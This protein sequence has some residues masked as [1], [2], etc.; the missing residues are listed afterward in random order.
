MYKIQILIHCVMGHTFLCSAAQLGCYWY[1]SEPM[2]E[3][4]TF[5]SRVEVQQTRHILAESSG[6]S[7]SLLQSI[8]GEKTFSQMS[9]ADAVIAQTIIIRVDT[10]LPFHLARL[11]CSSFH[12]QKMV[13]ALFVTFW[14]LECSFLRHLSG[15]WSFH[16][17]RVSGKARWL[18]SVMALTVQPWPT[19]LCPTGLWWE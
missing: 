14:P 7:P 5:L 6:F 2:R 18:M 17:Q 15:D 13:F 9:L 1:Y 4:G 8:W 19:V 10:Q 16:A 3:S 11:S 12:T